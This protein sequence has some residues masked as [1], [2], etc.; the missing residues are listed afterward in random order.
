M[1]TTDIHAIK[2]TVGVAIGYITKDKVEEKIKDDIADSIKYAINDKTGEVTYYTTS[3]VL[4][5]LGFIVRKT[6]RGK[7]THL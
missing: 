2:Q 1:A 7:I 3:S 4:K 6:S 5:R